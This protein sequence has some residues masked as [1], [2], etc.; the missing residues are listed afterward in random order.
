MHHNCA[1]LT[2]RLEPKDIAYLKK[3]GLSKKAIRLYELTLL[4]GPLS[5]KEAS[6]HT[7]TLPEAEYRLFYELENKQL[8]RRIDGWPRCFKALPLSDGLQASLLQEE[9]ELEKLVSKA[10]DNDSAGI[11]VG[12]EAVYRTYV[13]YAR[14]ARKQICI[15]AIGIA[16]SDELA[17]VQAGAIKRGVNIRHATQEIKP[18]NYYVIDRWLK[19]GIKVR[20]LKRPRGYHLVLID[21]NCAIVTFS[22]PNNTDHRV[23]LVTTQPHVAAIFQAQFEAI[24]RRAKP[25][26]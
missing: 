15:Y 8:I 11:I 16:Y 7:E 26:E 19:L 22:D 3:I 4:A 9:K 20:T 5:A 17:K 21:G 18:G 2:S 1:C 13:Q 14:Q 12:R 24:W 23:S 25:V 6:L 10:P